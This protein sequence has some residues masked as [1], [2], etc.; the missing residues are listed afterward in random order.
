MF[1]PAN[2]GS[3]GFA[4]EPGPAS[5]SSSPLFDAIPHR[6]STRADYDGRPVSPRDLDL[7]ASAATDPGVDL[8]LLT[9]RP[10]IDRLRE[11]VTTGNSAQMADPAFVRELKAWLRFNPHAALRSGDGLYSVA[12]GNPSL[13]DW[14]GPRA[15]DWLSTPLRKTRAT[16]RR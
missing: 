14:L 16:P 13:P 12:S 11:L 1:D 15:F 10:R 3:I 9:D 8:V 7:L 5:P 6:Q 4:H 2:G